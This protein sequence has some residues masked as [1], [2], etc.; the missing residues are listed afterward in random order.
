MWVAV[1]VA[2]VAGALMLAADAELAR[3]LLVALAA[4]L[5]VVV[6]QLYRRLERQGRWLLRLQERLDELSET[7]SS[8]V[9]SSTDV[10]D[11][12]AEA[13]DAAGNASPPN[14]ASSQPESSRPRVATAPMWG[15]RKAKAQTGPD[16]GER[17]VRWVKRWLTTGNVP[18]KVGV[19]ISF[20]GV[21]FL[22]KYA[23]EQNYLSFP[24]QWRLL[25][26]AV[27]ACAAL[28]FAWF[29][30]VQRPAFAL[31]LQGGAIGV[32]FLTV[33]AAFQLYQLLPTTVAFGLLVVLT[34]AAGVLALLQNAMAL[35]VLG[36]VGG[37]LAPLLISTGSGSHVALFTYYAILNGAVFGV[38]WFRAWRVLNLLGFVFTFVI[39]SLWGYQFYQPAYFASVQPFLILFFLMYLGISMAYALR[40]SIHLRSY[41]DSSLV[42]G[43]PL[44]AFALQTQLVEDFKY[45]SAISAAVLALVYLVS[46][47]GLL[48][49]R[50]RD[51][52]SLL[53]ESFVALAIGFATLA[54]PLALSAH[55]TAF[56]WALE[57]AAMVWLGTRQGRQLT[58][59]AGVLM[60]WLASG[61]LIMSLAEG[62]RWD[63]W[64][65]LNDWVL[66]GLLL[67]LTCMASARWL[68]PL[69]SWFKNMAPAIGWLLFATGGV[70]WFAILAQ[71]I[72][73]VTTAAWQPAGWLLLVAAT[74]ALLTLVQKR[75]R[76]YKV[77]V[78]L[79]G[80]LP[81]LLLTAVASLDATERYSSH[82]GWL[83]WPLALIV[84]AMV[85]NGRDTLLDKARPWQ[86]AMSVWLLA[87]LCGRDLYSLAADMVPGEIWSV[88]LT[89]GAAV[90]L[91]W[92]V[93]LCW[94]RQWCAVDTHGYDWSVRGV[95]PVLAVALIAALE[96][97]LLSPGDTAPLT[98]L[99]L[100]NP[101][102]LASIALALS[103][104]QWF[105]I[106]QLLGQVWG[107]YKA[108]YWVYLG[109]GGFAFVLVTGDV[110]RTVHHWMGVAF[111]AEAL[112]AS[113]RLQASLSVVWGLSALAVMIIGHRRV[114]RPVYLAGAAFMAA[115]VIKLLLVD[116]AQSDTLERIVSFIGVGLLLL[117]VGFMAPVPPKRAP[118]LSQDEEFE[119]DLD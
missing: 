92:F 55:W 7:S 33:F 61:A 44:V 78:T 25:G 76:W 81:L 74:G 80:Y 9:Q 46:A 37:F 86:R 93:V 114:L 71:D 20:F 113:V 40:Q 30:R 34:T 48:R 28:V 119:L 49:S 50:L 62:A 10:S 67:A 18:V 75:M 36:V 64:L 17:L 72:A 117:V 104:L 58:A 22:L 54:V 89:L 110:A 106:N 109:L 88:A 73:R 32:L 47:L 27:A 84:L 111:S 66:G 56:A 102:S 115:V 43:L 6:F 107:K 101:L 31:S 4:G 116:L 79:S 118:S 100:L 29:Q 26:V 87:L 19:L 45:G 82:G 3:L 53:G 69:T 97:L 12:A 41:V 95:G 59:G 5:V 35:A 16:Y 51:R 108:I 77:Q 11:T 24:V 85:F 60:Q 15:P 21:S 52:V 83:A 23:A 2:V 99:P 38:A 39:G 105:A 94:R 68:E 57:G 63:E 8:L 1:I 98:F 65:F 13:S 14:S 96:R 42:F 112:F 90:A 103:A 70:W 91:H